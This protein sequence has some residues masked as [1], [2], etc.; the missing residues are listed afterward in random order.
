[1]YWKLTRN[2]PSTVRLEEHANTDIANKLIGTCSYPLVWTL[3]RYASYR[4]DVVMLDVGK[5]VFR[6]YR[7]TVAKVK[8]FKFSRSGSRKFGSNVFSF[9]HFVPDLGS[10]RLGS[11]RFFPLTSI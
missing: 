4:R 5:Q 2:V 11:S 1:M 6:D 3:R 8:V 9:F 10:G 7:G